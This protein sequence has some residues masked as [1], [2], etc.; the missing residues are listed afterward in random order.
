VQVVQAL[1]SSFLRLVDDADDES[2]EDNSMLAAMGVMQALLTMMEAVESKIEVVAS[3]E[4]PLMP[5]FIRCVEADCDE[6]LSEALELMT[7]VTYSVP[8]VPANSPLWQLLPLLRDAARDFATESVNW[9]LAPIDNLISKG[10]AALMAH[11]QLIR[12]VLDIARSCL[13]DEAAKDLQESDCRGGPKLLDCLL[14]NCVGGIDGQ[15]P[16]II[17]ICFGRLQQTP[18]P[19][20]AL[21]SLLW[22]TFASCF[23]YSAELTLSLLEKGGMTAGAL[24]G[25]AA[26]LGGD[27]TQMR[28][29]DIKVATLGVSALL[30]LPNA[31]APMVI[32]SNRLLLVRLGISLGQKQAELAKRKAKEAEEEGEEEEDDDED[33][34]EGEELDD[35][36]EGIEDRRTLRIGDRVFKVDDLLKGNFDDEDD[37]ELSDEED[38]TSPIDGLDEFVAFSD[39]MQAA[40][41]EDTQLL[42]KAGLAAQPDVLLQLSETEAAALRQLI[43]AVVA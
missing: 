14:L 2:D 38:C 21:A 36:A 10:S 28:Q 16:E 40:C 11:P 31:S 27:D 32:A 17:A 13:V 34:D 43:E 42:G 25:W 20:P 9:M 37:D 4:G 1:V 26:H 41:A 5:L 39:A 30:R 8:D 35:D 23:Y 3:L 7:Y 33:E 12:C 15:L 6:F 19:G 22:T 18:P 29:H 24:Q